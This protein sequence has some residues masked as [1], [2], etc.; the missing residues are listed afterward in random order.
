MSSKPVAA[1]AGSDCR[2]RGA[3]ASLAARAAGMRR[4]QRLRQRREFSSVYRRGQQYRGRLLVLRVLKTDQ[5]LS[6]FG[7]SVGRAVGNAVT[8]N[9]I[10][11]RLREAVR[12]LPVAASW[13]VVLN[14]RRGAA[15]ASYAQLRT[16]VCEL[17]SQASLLEAD[18]R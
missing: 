2:S 11:R 3:E 16:E 18:S 6:R 8:R 7:F 4:E 1:K 14:V 15:E 9:R 17:M 13:D 10:K 5:P 12:S